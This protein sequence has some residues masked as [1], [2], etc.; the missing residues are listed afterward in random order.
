[1]QVAP[2]P[3]R[4][5]LPEGAERRPR[6]PAR[7]ALY[8]FLAG[9][10]PFLLLGLLGELATD[11]SEADTSVSAG[12]VIV[13]VL[14]LDSFLL[15]VAL[16]FA[17]RVRRPRPWHFGISRTAFWPAVGWALLGF[18]AFLTFGAI[19]QALLQPEVEQG[20]TDALGADQGTF[21]LIMA[22][23]MVIVLAPVAEEIFFRGFLYG[24]LRT[25]FGVIAAASINGAMFGVVHYDFSGLDALLIVPPLGVLGFIFCLVYERTGSIFPC[26]ALHAFNNALAYGIQTDGEGTPVSLALGVTVIA[27][28][29]VVP[30]FT[31]PATA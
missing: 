23:F 9:P 29:M 15:G 17:S 20:V 26:I 6:W 30:R 5:E 11:E 18:F 27:A 14:I 12:A 25:R 10:G 13:S 4:P 7:Y 31:R 3:E 8:A 1:M 24:A 16:L 19:Y 2:P 21:G 28:C 22:G